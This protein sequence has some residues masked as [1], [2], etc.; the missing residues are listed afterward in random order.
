MLQVQSDIDGFLFDS[1]DI[2][3]RPVICHPRLYANDA[4]QTCAEI[5]VENWDQM[6]TKGWKME[7]KLHQVSS[8]NKTQIMALKDIPP[9]GIQKEDR[10]DLCKA[11]VC[12]KAF[13]CFRMLGA[14]VC[15]RCIQNKLKCLFNVPEGEDD[16]GDDEDN[17]EDED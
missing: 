15:I 8:I 13:I 9:K 2:A 14:R 11:R 7:K 17:G 5:G 1:V 6:P 4:S 16:D 3:L 10:S 12:N